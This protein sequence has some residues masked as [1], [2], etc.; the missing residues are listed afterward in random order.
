MK[1]ERE[2]LHR[3]FLDLCWWSECEPFDTLLLYLAISACRVKMK[4]ATVPPTN[5]LEY[6]RAS[7]GHIVRLP[8]LI[9][10][11]CEHVQQALSGG[12]KMNA[13]MFYHMGRK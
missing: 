7:M 3:A 9:T 2:L 6:K 10:W 11:S 8:T 12:W 13:S 1:G 4:G 5:T